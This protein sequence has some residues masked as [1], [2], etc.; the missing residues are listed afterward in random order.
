[1]I[2]LIA[3]A[4]WAAPAKPAPVGMP[5]S[6]EAA[7]QTAYYAHCHIRTFKAAVGGANYGTQG[8]VNTYTID[9]HGLFHDRIP[10]PNAQCV[11]GKVKGDGPVTLH[12]FKDGD[13]KATATEAGKWVRLEVW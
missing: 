11:F 9:T 2:A 6:V 3:L 1:M 12:I 8:Y 4:L 13:H 10:S 5:V 7:P